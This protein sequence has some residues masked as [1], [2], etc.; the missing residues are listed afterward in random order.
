[1]LFLFVWLYTIYINY[2][3]VSLSR[4]NEWLEVTYFSNKEHVKHFWSYWEQQLRQDLQTLPPINSTI[5]EGSFAF[6]RAVYVRKSH[7]QTYWE[8]M[9]RYLE[10]PFHCA[11][12]DEIT[13]RKG[14]YCWEWGWLTMSWESGQRQ[15]I[16]VQK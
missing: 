13:K 7:C 16:G 1:M 5:G 10:W 14:R 12:F 8:N 2:T 4:K 6:V 15:F 9:V 3:A 11:N